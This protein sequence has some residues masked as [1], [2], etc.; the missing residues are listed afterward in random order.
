MF[1]SKNKS[2]RSKHG[3]MKTIVDIQLINGLN[4]LYNQIHHLLSCAT[5]YS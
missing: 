5:L 4:H 3:W 2:R 1:Q